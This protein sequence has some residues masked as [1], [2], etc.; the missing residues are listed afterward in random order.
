MSHSIQKEYAGRDRRFS[1][2][3]DQSSAAVSLYLAAA[4]F[5]FSVILVLWHREIYGF[6]TRSALFVRDMMEG[7]SLLVP[8]LYGRPY[9]DYPPLFFLLQYLASLPGGHLSALSVSLPSAFSATALVL[10]TW[11]FTKRHLGPGSALVSALCLA[12]LPEFWLKAEKATLDML[13]ALECGTALV[14]FFDADN[15]RDRKISLMFR[16]AGYAAALA[17]L[18]TKGPVGIILP[19]FCWFLYLALQKRVRD[20]IR[21][22]PVWAGLCL[23][24]LGLEV[25]LF[26]KAGGNHLLMEAVSDQFLSRIGG[27]ANKPFYYYFIYL[28]ISFLPW[29]IWMLPQLYASRNNGAL[30]AEKAQTD[31]HMEKRVRLFCVSW[32]AGVL[33]PFLL[34]SSRHGRY[35]L[36]AFMPLAI[37]A[38]HWVSTLAGRTGRKALAFMPRAVKVFLALVMLLALVLLLVDPAGSG[39]PVAAL[40]VLAACTLLLYHRARG[41]GAWAGTILTFAV[42][43]IFATSSS[44]LLIEP[45]I[46]RKECARAFTECTE[47]NLST[48]ERVVL[49]KMKPDKNGL[50]Y[51]LYSRAYPEGLVF[52]RDIHALSKITRPFILAGFRKDMD[53]PSLLPEKFFVSP[54]CTGKIHGKEAVSLRIE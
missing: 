17:G 29:L 20:I 8:H 33:I 32:A 42:A 10:L 45:G 19:L 53:L 51:A 52:V 16:S 18:F 41:I 26:I 1:L 49:Y 40:S 27:N 11:W 54:L 13:L 36:P 38:G 25:L 14:F 28:A 12:S 34:S 48:G 5:L 35:V 31:S 9:T 23:L 39:R 24:G 6:E 2:D 15:L 43:L 30:P 3:I 37:L 44:C 7:R 47:S 4:F 46:S 22:M 21:A 50:K